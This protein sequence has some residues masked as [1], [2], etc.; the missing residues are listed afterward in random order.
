M[1]YGCNVTLHTG[2]YF[3]FKKLQTVIYSF[4]TLHIPCTNLYNVYQEPT[5]CICFH[6]RIFILNSYTFRSAIR[7]SS[8][9]ISVVRMQGDQVC[10]IK[11]VTEIKCILLVLDTHYSDVFIKRLLSAGDVPTF[12]MNLSMITDLP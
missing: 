9:V 10:Q 11:Y 7:P 8:D 2:Q 6:R 12:I 1:T 5:K 4:N 3:L